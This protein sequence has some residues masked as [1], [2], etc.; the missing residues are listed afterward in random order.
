MDAMHDLKQPTHSII[1][2]IISGLEKVQHVMDIMDL[3]IQCIEPLIAVV[4]MCMLGHIELMQL[5]QHHPLNMEV[6]D[7]SSRIP[8]AL[9][10]VLHL[11]EFWNSP[12]C[13]PLDL[14]PTTSFQAFLLIFIRTPLMLDSNT[15]FLNSK[16]VKNTFTKSG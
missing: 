4:V 1:L 12:S 2:R 11:V 7:F 8:Q 14:S 5:V 3:A 10:I 9:T 13:T 16:L 6:L 15:S